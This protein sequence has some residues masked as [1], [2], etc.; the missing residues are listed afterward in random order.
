MKNE[1]IS[2]IC[3]N[4]LNFCI[5]SPSL[6]NHAYA[7]NDPSILLRIAVQADKQIVNQLDKYMEIKFQIIYK[8]YMIK[9]M[10]L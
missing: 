5:S 4:C 10:E 8:F 3:N 1:K 7:Q 2:S 6:V 9:V